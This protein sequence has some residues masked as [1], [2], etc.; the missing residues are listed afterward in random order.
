MGLGSNIEPRE[1]YLIQALL[2]VK[3]L[4]LLRSI[5]PL[6]E[7]EPYGKTDQSKFLNTAAILETEIL[8]EK[9]L[10]QLKKI[11]KS[12]GRKKR[13]RWGPREIDIDIIF[14]G[15]EIIRN[16]SLSVPHPDY[17]NR[18]FVLQPLADLNADF[19]PPDDHR[20]L[21]ALL[22]ECPDQSELNVW[23]KEWL[24]HGA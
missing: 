15:Q 24:H 10:K 23:K 12:A 16:Q 21:S 1:V 9:L 3:Y 17:K 19:I 20:T 5:A 7:S 8:A 11:E 2:K 18:R 13:V 6:Y 14:Y 4:G 22:K